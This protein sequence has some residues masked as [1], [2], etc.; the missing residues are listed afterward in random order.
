MNAGY[1]VRA[2]YR[3]GV[4]MGVS[5]STLECKGHCRQKRALRGVYDRLRDIV[6]STALT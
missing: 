1:N 6:R 3:A 5:G 2:F 4:R